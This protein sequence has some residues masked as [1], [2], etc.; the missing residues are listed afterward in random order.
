MRLGLRST[1]LASFATVSL[2]AFA[3]GAIG[4][5]NISSLSKK[6]QEVADTAMPAVDNFLR[7]SNII[8]GLLDSIHTL[9]L[10]QITTEERTRLFEEVAQKRAEYGACLKR[11]DELELGAERDAQLAQLK[12][13]IKDWAGLNNKGLEILRQLMA[14]DLSD[15]VQMECWLEGFSSDHYAALDK[16]GRQI[17]V[18]QAYEG[19]AEAQKCRFGEWAASHKSKNK[20]LGKVLVEVR[21]SHDRFHASIG[22]IQKQLS[23]GN[24]EDAQRILHDEMAPAAQHVMGAFKEM[25]SETA[26]GRDAYAKAIQSILVEGK[27]R[28][29]KVFSLMH[30]IVGA[31]EKSAAE[32]A[33]STVEASNA[34]KM[35]MVI[36]VLGGMGVAIVLGLVIS[37][38]VSRRLSLLSAQVA[39]SSEQIASASQQVAS[40]SASLAE[41]A[42]AQAASLEESSSA[43][44]EL[45]SMAQRNG[46]QASRA[47]ETAGSART[48]AERGAE[49]MRGMSSAMNDIQESS[50]DIGK[51]VKTIDEIAFQTNILALNAAVEAARAGESGAGFAVVAEEVRALA[52]RSANAAKETTALVETAV[53]RTR[54]GVALC[55]RVAGGFTTLLERSREVDGF[56]GEIAHASKEQGDGMSQISSSINEMDSVVQRNASGS[57]EAASAAQEMHAQ[58]VELQRA[59]GLLEE[60]I[61]GV[62]KTGTE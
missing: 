18:Q 45:H 15:P 53:T 17:A 62:Q 6:V 47:K 22:A 44:H 31:V 38:S 41:G 16:A 26:R 39:A 10:P 23:Q 59:V 2:C 55:D 28:Q 3:V 56:A 37:T 11:L 40:A 29:V 49:D 36:G 61:T 5:Y 19:G 58:A 8:Q 1:L 48:A 52:Q 21:A 32:D 13:E 60:L 50:A 42:S 25:L 9:M 51:I 33:D 35:Y 24:A 54:E 57:E 7:V 46:E 14:D 20:V 43:L 27:E 4:Y 34:A 12:G 30:T